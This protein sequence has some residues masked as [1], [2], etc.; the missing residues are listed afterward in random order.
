MPNWIEDHQQV[1]QFD[2][3]LSTLLNFLHPSFQDKY[4]KL[5]NWEPNWIAKAIRLARDMWV[6]HYK[7]K[8]LPVTTTSATPTLPSRPKT[9]MLSGLSE[10]ATAQGGNRSS[11][12]F[13]IWLTRGLVL[14]GNNPVN[15][16]KWWIQQKRS[17]NTHGGLVHM[18]LDVL[19]CPGTSVDF[20]R[21][22]SFGSNYVTLRRHRLTPKSWEVP[23]GTCQ[24]YS[25][26]P[27]G[28]AACGAWY[29]VL[30]KNSQVPGCK[31]VPG[32]AGAFLT[33]NKNP[34]QLL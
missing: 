17:G 12:A 16:L 22:F 1:L 25:R 23:A 30:A 6:S 32:S 28:G 11:D 3:L 4:F 34:S 15:P 27:P 10:A 29:W 20:E 13:N 5:A 2:R 7:P 9:G 33:R 31:R 14:D 18:A 8:S 24:K 19:S 26:Y 21:S